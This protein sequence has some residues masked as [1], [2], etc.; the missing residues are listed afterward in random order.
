[1]PV[2]NASEETRCIRVR[3]GE[4]VSLLVSSVYS[5]RKKKKMRLRNVFKAGTGAPLL[6]REL[7]EKLTDSD[8]QLGRVALSNL[9]RPAPAS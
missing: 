6:H 7:N 2:T 4:P 5:L 3:Y 1:M 9:F 8:D